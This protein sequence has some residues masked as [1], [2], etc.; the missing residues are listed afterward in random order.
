MRD[1]QF[2]KLVNDIDF[3][4]AND[5]QKRSDLR[6]MLAEAVRNTAAMQSDAQDADRGS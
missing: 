1:T 6:R 3:R 2:K 4:R 5:Q